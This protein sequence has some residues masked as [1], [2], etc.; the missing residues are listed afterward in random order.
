MLGEIN[1]EKHVEKGLRMPSFGVWALPWRGQGGVN[2][3]LCF[4]K[5]KSG[6]DEKRKVTLE[7]GEIVQ[8]RVHA[9]NKAGADLERRG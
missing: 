3:N 7:V 6:M 9:L 8:R 2:S 1:L 4:G 5:I